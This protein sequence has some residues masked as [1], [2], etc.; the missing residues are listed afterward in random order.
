MLAEGATLICRSSTNVES[1]EFCTD[2][3]DGYSAPQLTIES[4][5]AQYLVHYQA[6]RYVISNGNIVI[7]RNRHRER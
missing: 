3:E 5:L 4:E 1:G 2:F 7:Y 6:A